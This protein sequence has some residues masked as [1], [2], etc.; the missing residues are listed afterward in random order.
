MEDGM[1]TDR[2]RSFSDVLEDVVSNVQGIIRSEVRLAKAEI[3][4]ETVK[5]GKAAR[6][7]G[8]GVVLAVYGLGFLLLTCLYALETAITP[9]F[10]ALIMMLLVGIPAAVLVIA[11]IKR[12]KRV[13]PRPDKTIRTIR[14]NLEWAKDQMR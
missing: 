5:A 13:D 10:A 9:W 7:V 11:G 4:E 12:M 6:I 1:A 2:D 3:Q 8:F 14:E